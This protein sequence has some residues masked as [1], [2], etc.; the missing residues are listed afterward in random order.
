MN[1]AT[2]KIAICAEQNPERSVLHL[3]D[4]MRKKAEE[5]SS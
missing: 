4:Q 5:R 1:V 3:I 2:L